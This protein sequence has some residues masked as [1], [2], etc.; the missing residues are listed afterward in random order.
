MDPARITLSGAPE[1]YDAL[2]IARELARTGGPVVHVARDARRMAAI[3][4]ALDFFAP[5]VPRISFPGWDCLPYD[6]VSPHADVSSARMAT[7]A[8]LARGLA[9]RLIVVTTL[10]PATQRVPSR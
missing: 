6:R 5:D 3:E 4:A 1:G 2:L 7:L 9:G 10:N 8:T